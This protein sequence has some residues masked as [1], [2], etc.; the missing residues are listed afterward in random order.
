MVSFYYG[1]LY[2]SITYYFL[3]FLEHFGWTINASLAGF[4][5]RLLSILSGALVW[6]S[7]WRLGNICNLPTAVAAA[8]ALAML[9]MPDFVFFSRLMHPDVLQTFFVIVS[10]G[11]LRSARHFRSP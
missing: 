3:A 11:P 4:V 6:L 5:L 1:N 8:A 7:L 10:L 9:T 2:H